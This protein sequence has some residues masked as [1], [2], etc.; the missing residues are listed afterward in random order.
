MIKKKNF[1]LL[2]LLGYLECDK[3]C[4]W[5]TVWG[6]WGN[7]GWLIR[8][9]FNFPVNSCKQKEI[10]MWLMIVLK[11]TV[12]KYGKIRFLLG[13]QITESQKGWGWDFWRLSGLHT[14]SSINLWSTLSVTALQIQKWETGDHLEGWVEVASNNT[15]AIKQAMVDLLPWTCLYM[16]S[17]DKFYFTLFRRK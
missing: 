17:K 10:Q 3:G 16:C 15:N 11:D 13:L 2:R 9:K 8:L 14:G 5:T 4:Y 1:F 12:G 6:L 7:K